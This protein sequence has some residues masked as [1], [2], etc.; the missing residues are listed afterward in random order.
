MPDCNQSHLA[1][2]V[3]RL[4]QRARTVLGCWK[5][6]AWASSRCCVD[7]LSR[8]R[9]Q[10]LGEHAPVLHGERGVMFPR[11]SLAAWDGTGENHAAAPL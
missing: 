6:C 11:I 10:D 7:R 5:P 1:R 8:Q 4:N 3:F 2:M 9:L